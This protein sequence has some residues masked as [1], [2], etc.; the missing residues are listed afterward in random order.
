M[1]ITGATQKKVPEEAGDVE[2][3]D[4]LDKKPPKSFYY[5]NLGETIF[6]ITWC[7]VMSNAMGSFQ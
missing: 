4:G 7:R 2:A 6:E 5:I 3:K 1:L